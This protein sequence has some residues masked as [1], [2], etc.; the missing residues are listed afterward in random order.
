MDQCDDFKV[1]N[2]N[3]RRIEKKYKK[4]FD[5]YDKLTSFFRKD[6]QPANNHE[7]KIKYNT[8]KSQTKQKP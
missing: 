6:K 1:I 5:L 2:L 4:I 7:K 3:Q 8:E